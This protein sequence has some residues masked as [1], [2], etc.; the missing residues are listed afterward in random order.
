MCRVL[1][2]LQ[3][4]VLTYCILYV[5]LVPQFCLPQLKLYIDLRWD[6]AYVVLVLHGILFYVTVDNVIAA[7][8]TLITAQYHYNDV[9][10]L[11]M[12]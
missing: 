10:S 5:V 2:T 1:R 3:D 11:L 7:C 6:H 8:I 12:R 9:T 4:T